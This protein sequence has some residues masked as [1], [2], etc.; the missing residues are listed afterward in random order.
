MKYDRAI[1]HGVQ[2]IYETACEPQNF[3][4]YGFDYLFSFYWI[5][6]TSKDCAL[7]TL[8]RKWGRD[9]ARRWRRQFASV[10]P[11]ADPE[12]ITQMVF[13]G[14][15]ADR[16]GVRS[17]GFKAMTLTGARA[18]QAS[19]YY[20]FEPSNEPPA[21]DVPEDCSCGVSNR[22]GCRVCRRCRRRLP[23]MSQYE[24]WLDALI[25]SYL[26]ERYRVKLGAKYADVLKWL[27]L[28]RPYPK[29]EVGDNSDFIWSIYAVTHVVYTLNDYGTYLLS[30]HWLPTEF[31]FLRCS[32]S[33]FI[34][35][36]D[37]ETVGEILDSLKAFGMS[38]NHSLIRSGMQYLL[39]RQNT[40]GS[41]GDLDSNDIYD[42][43]HPTLT[44]VNG[45]R[46][47][48]WTITR[49]SFP[50]LEPAL[51]KWAATS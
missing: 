50:A 25:R 11:D 28:M 39:S 12:V 10:P 34:D 4:L 35:M 21:T 22:R 16:L 9:C 49:L 3:E 47:Y 48:S 15:S 45:L 8:A 13:G 18:F 44:A 36:D 29:P 1:L 19:D 17:P 33:H 37:P 46:E 32:L 14:L 27:P 42:R 38:P 51:R 24:V 5:C 2:F 26:G 20:S 43:Y 40:D 31:E 41:W 6:S 23:M 7:R 30:P